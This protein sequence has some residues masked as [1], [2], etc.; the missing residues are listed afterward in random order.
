[1]RAGVGTVDRL[2]DGAT[3]FKEG[4]RVV[5]A[6]WSAK[7]GDGTWQQYAVVD[8][9]ALIGVPDSVSDESAAQAIVNPVTA[10]GFLDVSKVTVTSLTGSLQQ[11]KLS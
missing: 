4:Q 9:T 7:R 11:Q 8:E 10:Y 5:A 3:R 2:G 6:P 1:M